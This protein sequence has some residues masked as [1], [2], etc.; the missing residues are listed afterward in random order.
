MKQYW[1]G[2]SKDDGQTAVAS[3]EQYKTLAQQLSTWRSLRNRK[4]LIA[5]AEQLAKADVSALTEDQARLKT[6]T[7]GLGDKAVGESSSERINRLRQIGARQDIQSIL[8]DRV[9][10]YQQLAA[11]YGRW[12]GQ[13]EIQRKIVVHLI[14]QSLALIAAICML[15]ILASCVLQLGIGESGSRSSPKTDV[16]NSSKSGNTTGRPLTNPADH[17]RRTTADAND[18]GPGDRRTDRGLS[19][20]HPGI[21]R[22]VCSDGTKRSSG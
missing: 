9:G 5:Q 17:F 4:Q 21:L 16:E 6:E 3:A 19:G 20:L 12:G 18:P 10:A 13:V 1:D 15:V 8:N 2:A 7:A 11:L 14:L 22:L